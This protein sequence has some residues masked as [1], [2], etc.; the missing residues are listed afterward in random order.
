MRS[1]SMMG[2]ASDSPLLAGLSR[3][4]C[5]QGGVEKRGETL[6]FDKAARHSEPTAGDRQFLVARS[7]RQEYAFFAA[8]S[9]Q[10]Q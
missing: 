3:R 9:T 6:G 4:L 10:I 7:R 1:E 8:R 5:S 2:Q